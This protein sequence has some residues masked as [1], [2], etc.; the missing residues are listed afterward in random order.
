ME[1]LERG[2]VAEYKGDAKGHKER[3][4]QN[5]RVRAM[6]EELREKAKRLVR[7]F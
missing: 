6:L 4:L 2:I 7:P 1:R 3:L 5:H